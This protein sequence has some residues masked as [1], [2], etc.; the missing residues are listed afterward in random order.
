MHNA[1]AIKAWMDNGIKYVVG[2]NTRTP[3]VN[4]VS[5]RFRLAYIRPP[6]IFTAK[7]L[8]AIDFVSEG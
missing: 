5:L 7:R 3:L 4:H 2:D 1:D 8:V 6:D